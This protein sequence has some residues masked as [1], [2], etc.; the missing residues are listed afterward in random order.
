MGSVVESI[1]AKNELN[2]YSLKAPA[3]ESSR[4]NVEELKKRKANEK[5]DKFYSKNQK[6]ALIK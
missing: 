5:I 1:E 4:Q 6:K 3:K 2:F